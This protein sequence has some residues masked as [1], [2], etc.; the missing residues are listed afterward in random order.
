[1]NISVARLRWLY[2]RG[3]LWWMGLGSTAIG[4]AILLVLF[5][6]W[7][8]EHKFDANAVQAVAK[9]TG[10][11][12]RTVMGGRQGNTPRT[13]HVL[14]F[15][16][17]D[18][19]GQQHSGNAE[20]SADTWGRAKSGDDLTIEYDRTNPASTRLAGQV[21]TMG[22]IGFAI[23]GGIGLL[24]A[25]VGLVLVACVL[26]R[27]GRRVRLIQTGVPAIGVVTGVAEDGGAVKVTGTYR[28]AYQ[29]AD[30]SGATWPGRGPPQPYSLA[31]RWNP[32]DAMLVLYDPRNP[33]RNEAD[34]FE[35]RSDELAALQDQM[36]MDAAAG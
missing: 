34:L 36:E 30:P 13:V 15:T 3:A 10:K 20:V 8:Y 25:I 2:I 12:R 19:A 21:S 11:D 22:P 6:L 23:L 31:F 17:Q 24:F 29:F 5:L 26:V 32:G 18:G 27:S 16:F 1:M 28:V 9:V 4:M 14:D 7:Q 33:N 35:T